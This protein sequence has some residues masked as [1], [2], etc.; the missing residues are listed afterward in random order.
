MTERT[1]MPM[2]PMAQ[3]CRRMMEKPFS[4]VMLIVPGIVF[5]LLGVAIVLE[6]VILAWLIAFA[7]I[8]F[9]IMLL[10]MAGFVRRVGTQVRTTR[11]DAP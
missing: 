11:G 6:P 8:L 5:M 9:G 2:C 3:G 1:P 7:F 4:G 10:M